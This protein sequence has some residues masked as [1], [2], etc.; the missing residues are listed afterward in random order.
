MPVRVASPTPHLEPSSPDASDLW[1]VSAYRLNLP[2]GATAESSSVKYAEFDV[3]FVASA[4]FE[5]PQRA[6]TS[7]SAGSLITVSV[8]TFTKTISV[9]HIKGKF[10][11]QVVAGLVTVLADDLLIG[12]LA[13]EGPVE[14]P[15]YDESQLRS[16]PATAAEP[17]AIA[18]LRRATERH[19]PAIYE[20]VHEPRLSIAVRWFQQGAEEADPAE[21]FVD[22]WLCIHSLIDSFPYAV[23]I[24]RL[25]GRIKAYA[26]ESLNL[27][28]TESEDL[29][30]A[31]DELH[32]KRNQLFH[33]RSIADITP[34]MAE[35]AMRVAVH[36]LRAEIL[37]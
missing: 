9:A 25:R 2:K 15:A 3:G 19:L 5:H 33:D 4:D 24:E 36:F 1:W 26:A 29:L 28:P 20:K 7:R 13:W 10:K 16:E 31:I 17:A 12:D 32:H 14:H 34:D 35:K 30:G 6:T 22:Y 23:P 8:P 37:S 11:A 27:G 18:R 21:Q